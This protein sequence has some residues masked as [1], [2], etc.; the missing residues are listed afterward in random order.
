MDDSNV[1][2]KL[3]NE[4]QKKAYNLIKHWLEETVYLLDT[5]S[6]NQVKQMLLQIDG[7]GSIHKLCCK[8]F[9]VRQSNEVGMG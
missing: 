2:P 3:L 7:K 1:S 4:C 6:G 9:V 5:N 8:I